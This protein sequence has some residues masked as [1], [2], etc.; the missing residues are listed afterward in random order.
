MPVCI[1]CYDLGGPEAP[2]SYQ[3]LKKLIEALPNC[4]A[5][6]SVWF[7]EH[8]GPAEALRDHLAQV[9][10][11]NDRIFVDQVSGAW[12]GRGMPI[13]GRWLNERG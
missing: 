12:A 13:C 2:A 4:H 10:D 5:Q 3:R 8:Q 11:S 1:V 6:Q 7:V 9:L